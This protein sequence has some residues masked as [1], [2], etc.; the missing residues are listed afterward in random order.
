MSEVTEGVCTKCGKHPVKENGLCG[1][2]IRREGGGG[3]KPGSARKKKCLD[4][5]A[6]TVNASDKNHKLSVAFDID[7][8]ISN[9]RINGNWPDPAKDSEGKAKEE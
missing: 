1:W 9:V 4:M 2:C 5:S 3:K 6:V 8:N 7:V